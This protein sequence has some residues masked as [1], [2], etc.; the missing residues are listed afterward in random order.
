MKSISLIASILILI[1]SLLWCMSGG[2]N[3][4]LMI[5]EYSLDP[6]IVMP[7]D[8][9]LL[10][11][12]VT[13]GEATSTYTSASTSGGT[14]TTTV[15]TV[16]AT[17]SNMWVEQ[18]TDDQGCRLRALL[19]YEDFGYI[20]P[21]GS[22]DVSF[23]L[24]ADESLT[25][26]K[27]FPVVHIDL[28]S[29]LY[30]DVAYPIPVTVSNAT[31]ELIA[32]D[33]PSKL[34]VSGSTDMSLTVVNHRDAAV[35]GVVITVDDAAGVDIMPN[36]IFIGELAADSTEDISVTL[37]PKEIGE[38]NLSFNASYKNG[39]N[40][41][42]EDLI[43]PVEVID[44]LDVAPVLYSMPST[45]E[46]GKTTRVRLEVY[47][48]KTSEITGVIVTPISEARLSPS[49]YFIGSMDPDDVFSASFDVDTSSLDLGSYDIGFKVAFKQDENYYET[50]MVSASFEV[51]TPVD[52]GQSAGFILP[53]IGVVCLGGIIIGYVYFR[54]YRRKRK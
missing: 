9:A 34:S 25:E 51:V 16:G 50:P 15:K 22:F 7:G 26:G 21:S 36:R 18:D 4:A 2:A 42:Y 27:Y 37:I 44:V 38:M 49:Q 30:E 40:L 32:S 10:T 13:N 8:S 46:Q 19:N 23:E 11:V 28:E 29:T 45:I 1:L 43:V 41:H 12:T 33:G 54:K 5:T 31:L 47:N 6:A 14:T 20:A 35:D 52:E 3:P 48:A 17:I 53:I 39:D 24:V